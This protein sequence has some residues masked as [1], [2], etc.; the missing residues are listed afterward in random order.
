MT[1]FRTF[2]LAVALALLLPLMLFGCA[3]LVGQK[4]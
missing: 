1:K 2:S 4:I 3:T